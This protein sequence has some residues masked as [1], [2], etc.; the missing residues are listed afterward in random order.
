MADY[1]MMYEKIFNKVS[2]VITQMQII[3]Q[4]TESMYIES[5]E[6]DMKLMELT[7]KSEQESNEH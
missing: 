2:D 4:Q 6:P 5:D 1:K 7:H 3:Q